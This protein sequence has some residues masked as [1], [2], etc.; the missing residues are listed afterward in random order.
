LGSGSS[1]VSAVSDFTAKAQAETKGQ[2]P[3]PFGKYESVR[4][5]LTPPAFP[6]MRSSSATSGMTCSIQRISTAGQQRDRNGES[7]TAGNGNRATAGQA[8]VTIHGF[9]EN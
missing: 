3:I 4:A 2:P 7:A 5:N 6:V 1:A 8:T 9:R